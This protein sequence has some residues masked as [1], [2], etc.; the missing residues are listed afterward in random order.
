MG[1]STHVIGFVAPDATWKKMKAVWDACELAG[2]EAP[3]EVLKFFAY[4]EPDD[5]GA[6]ISLPVTEWDD[7]SGCQGFELEVAKI[8][9]NV[10]SIRF[11]N[12]W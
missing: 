9:P 5:R 8:P 3:K 10:T 1:M 11:Y 6:H 7:G 2:I 4:E 12:S